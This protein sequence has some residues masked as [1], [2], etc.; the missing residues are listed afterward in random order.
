MFI[1]RVLAIYSFCPS[2]V[3]RNRNNYIDVVAKFNDFG[4]VSYFFTVLFSSSVGPFKSIY[5]CIN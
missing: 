3:K 4:T 5:T 2:T 1:L